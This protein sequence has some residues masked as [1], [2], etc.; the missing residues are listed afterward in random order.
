MKE[1]KRKAE[2]RKLQITLERLVCGYC[3]VVGRILNCGF[4]GEKKRKKKAYTRRRQMKHSCTRPKSLALKVG[5][6]EIKKTTSN[7]TCYFFLFNCLSCFFL[8]L[9]FSFI[10]LPNSSHCC[11]WLASESCCWI[12]FRYRL[13]FFRCV[14]VN[15][16]HI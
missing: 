1:R 13:F 6:D 3:G 15:L 4:I 5:V 16:G 10:Y 2:Q 12:L 8:F 7:S 9:Y 11:C 14:A